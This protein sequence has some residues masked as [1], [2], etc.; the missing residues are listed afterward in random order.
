MPKRT[1]KP[2]SPAARQILSVLS[3]PK[4]ASKELADLR[5]WKADAVV[6]LKQVEFGIPGS[7]KCPSCFGW[8]ASDNGETPLQ[9]TK[10][11]PLAKLLVGVP[12]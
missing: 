6:V 4:A 5:Q 10:E 12:R 9:H 7:R 3:R 2:T 1:K 11:C 8:N